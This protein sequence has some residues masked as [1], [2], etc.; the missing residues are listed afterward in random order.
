MMLD[1]VSGEVTVCNAANEEWMLNAQYPAWGQDAS[2]YL[3]ALFQ[4]PYL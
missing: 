2:Y 3:C 1:A 4:G